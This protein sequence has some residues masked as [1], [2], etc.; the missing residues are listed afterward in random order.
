MPVDIVTRPHVGCTLLRPLEIILSVGKEVLK[1]RYERVDVV[2][3]IE[4]GELPVVGEFLHDDVVV[5]KGWETRCNRLN[6]CDSE[7]VVPRGIDKCV[8]L[9]QQMRH[10][11]AEPIECHIAV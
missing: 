3:L 11:V 7:T 9:G 5:H 2:R 6:N 4:G 10:I 8:H 1:M